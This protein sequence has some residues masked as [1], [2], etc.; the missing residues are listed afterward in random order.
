M[1]ILLDTSVL[2]AAERGRFDLA[3]W[4]ADHA[5]DDVAISAVTA[6]ELLHG[7]A[8]ATTPYREKRRVYVE[9]FLDRVPSLPFD[10]AAARVHANLWADLHQRG[11]G[12]GAHDLL[13]AAT[14]F[15]LDAR[16]LTCDR[17][18]YRNIPGIELILIQ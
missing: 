10:L 4:M 15:S 16:L 3:A 9:G 6:S 8:R 2:I 13:I 12:A 7:L 18:L 14:A 1:K 5:D 17:K 11:Q